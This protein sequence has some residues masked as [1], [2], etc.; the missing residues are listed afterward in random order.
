VQI[1]TH[2]KVNAATEG[3]F[4]DVE[5]AWGG[6]PLPRQLAEFKFKQVTRNFC[7]VTRHREALLPSLTCT[8]EMDTR[9]EY[10]K[11]KSVKWLMAP[12]LIEI[13]AEDIAAAHNDRNAREITK[14]TII[15]PS[16]NDLA[17]LFQF[18]HSL[19]PNPQKGGG[20]SRQPRCDRNRP[21][22]RQSGQCGMLHSCLYFIMTL[23]V[24]RHTS[25]VTR[26]T[27]H[28]THHTSHITP[29]RC[30]IRWVQCLT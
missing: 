26:Y 19:T 22:R 13:S 23:H 29:S 21:L 12:G 2:L 30:Y 25:H 3:K 15:Q 16:P 8:Q 14:Y 18:V 9:V 11:A 4:E 6:Q 5:V 20:S 27:S 24:I 10:D 17:F 7:S 1:V 28:V